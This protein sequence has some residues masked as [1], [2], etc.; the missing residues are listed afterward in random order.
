MHE[1][2]RDPAATR[3][4]MR[5]DVIQPAAAAVEAGEGGGHDATAVAAD[6]AQAR[7]PSCHCRERRIVIARPVANPASAPKRAKL[8]AVALAKVAYLHGRPY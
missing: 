6:D 5:G 8:V 4:G 3:F 1:T 7:V 2:R